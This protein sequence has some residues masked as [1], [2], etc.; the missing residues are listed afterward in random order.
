MTLGAND[1]FDISAS[2]I[3]D[4]TISAALTASSDNLVT[5][6]S[7]T[8]LPNSEAGTDGET[9]E[10]DG[11][12]L[13][14]YSIGDITIENT[15]TIGIG[16][17]ALFDSSSDNNNVFHALGAIGDITLQGG[18]SEN[19]QTALFAAGTDGAVF[20]AS[21]AS[22]ADYNALNSASIIYWDGNTG[23][24]ETYSDLSG[25]TVSIGNVYINTA[26]E[27]PAS[28]SDSIADI[29]GDLTTTAWSGLNIF[30]G[31]TASHATINN[32][33][34]DVECSEVFE[35]TELMVAQDS[36]LT[37]TIGTITITN[38]VQ[39]LTVPA[40]V[41]ADIENNIPS[42]TSDF[43]SAIVAAT[44]VGAI[45]GASYT[46]DASSEWVEVGDSGAEDDYDA[47][48]I[49]VYIA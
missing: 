36:D 24:G 3:G 25:G 14:N 44:S 31:V 38:K 47:H 17:T 19:V 10:T 32:A 8:A 6:L 2:S 12:D 43:Y 27:N 42:S 16:S 46:A 34:D 29:H 1:V 5:D 9:V 49:T 18:G 23:T 28:D 7:V 37:G 26:S 22:N 13:G 15:N 20:Y 21:G 40:A 45:N 30:A 48:E 35:A 11:S 33:M 41:D 4:I 39:Q